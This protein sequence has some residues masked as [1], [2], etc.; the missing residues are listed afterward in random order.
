[1][2]NIAL[3]IK[4]LHKQCRLRFFGSRKVW[5]LCKKTSWRTSYCL[6]SAAGL[7]LYS[8]GMAR[9]S[10]PLFN[11]HCNVS[12]P[13]I[14]CKEG[15]TCITC[16][17]VVLQW[18]WERA[19]VN[20]LKLKAP[21]RM[22][23]WVARSV[24]YC[25]SIMI[26]VGCTSQPDIYRLVDDM[27]CT[28]RDRSGGHHPSK[29]GH[30]HYQSWMDTVWRPTLDLEQTFFTPAFHY[31]LCDSASASAHPASLRFRRLY[32]M[33]TLWWWSLSLS[34]LCAWTWSMCKSEQLGFSQWWTS[35]IANWTVGL[36][37][38]Q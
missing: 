16:V 33:W 23:V 3:L 14:P 21:R 37:N 7:G 26:A 31:L 20:V 17:R 10:G 12:S 2:W 15:N 35:V 34:S 1:M 4:P 13:R 18:R 5:G 8:M 24:M 6:S 9:C 11:V 30:P 28:W 38:D 36:L 32:S 19:N 29:N 25:H 27:S 22:S